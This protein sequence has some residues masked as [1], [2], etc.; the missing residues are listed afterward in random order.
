MAV[1]LVTGGTGLIGKFLCK[2]LQS[3]GHSVFILS[4]KKT[5]NPSYFYRAVANLNHQ[6]RT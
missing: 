1:V 3:K 6:L 2:L 4:R 5:A